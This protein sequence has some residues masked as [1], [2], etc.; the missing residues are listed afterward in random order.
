MKNFIGIFIFLLLTNFL[1]PLAYSKAY[2]IIPSKSYENITED[3]KDNESSNDN[4]TLYDEETKS[5]INISLKDY[6]IGAAACEM[7]ATYEENAIKAQMVAIHSYYLYC[8]N[9]PDFLENGLISVNEKNL[10]GYASKNKLNEFWGTSFYDYYAKFERCYEEVKDVIV[11]YDNLPALTTYYAVSCGKTQN[12]EDQWGRPLPYLITVDSQVDVVSEKY[13]Q[14]KKMTESE[15]FSLLKLN[16]PNINIDEETPENWFGDIVYYDSG[17]AQ[18]I[19]IGDDL[20][21]ANQL[22]DILKLPS[23]CMMI[24][25]E[26]GEFSIATKGYGHGVGLSQFGANQLSQQGKSYNEI[27]SYYYPNTTIEKI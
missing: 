13:L 25:R 18:Y 23:T 3:T 12:S 19:T 24:F 26:D 2:A 6:I 5:E 21:P 9:N 11:K 1:V 14:M 16:F 8:T 4:V 22:R 17:Y 15:M 20:V 7:P 27:L 10:K